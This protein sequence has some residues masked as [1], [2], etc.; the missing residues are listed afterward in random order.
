[1]TPP[2]LPCDVAFDR[3][4]AFLYHSFLPASPDEYVDVA[5]LDGFVRGLVF[6]APLP[7]APA[8]PTTADA[9]D[10]LSCSYLD[11]VAHLIRVG[12]T[13]LGSQRIQPWESAALFN[14]ACEAVSKAH[15]LP[16]STWKPR[17]YSTPIPS[18]FPAPALFGFC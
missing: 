5:T 10:A 2:Q 11:S 4:L 18:L 14:E 7:A 9:S 3:L 15:V 8:P 17:L 12:V 1:M 6:A 16:V 13:R